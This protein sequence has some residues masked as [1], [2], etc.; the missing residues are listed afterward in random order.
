MIHTILAGLTAASSWCWESRAGTSARGETSTLFKRAAMLALV[1][2]VPVSAFNLWFGSHFGDRDD[3]RSADEDRRR[4]GAVGHRPAGVVLAVPDRRLLQSDPTPAFSIEVPE[5]LSYLS[6][7]SLDG[8]VLGLNQL[9]RQERAK[10]GQGNYI[11]DV[12]VAYWSMRVMAYGGSLVFLVAAVGAY[13]Y[14]RGK[15]E[16]ARW[17]RWVAVATIAVPF[18]AALAGWLLTE[19]GRQPWI[20]QGLLKTSDAS[21]PERRD[22]DDRASLTVFVSLY[23]LLGIA[24][25][26]L[27]RRYARLDPPPAG[28]TSGGDRPH[29]P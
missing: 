6:T 13:L 11:P 1:V 9:Q 23:L 14:R 12:R 3:R 8:K 10:Y 15:L 25:F 17:Y 4:R 29:G 16:T 24:D 20:V 28:G 27:M 21:S 26:V 22:M 19:V 2:A 5:L 18:I 7:G